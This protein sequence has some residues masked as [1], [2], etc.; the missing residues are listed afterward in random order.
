MTADKPEV[1]EAIGIDLR[2]VNCD[3]ESW[4]Q[5]RVLTAMRMAVRVSQERKVQADQPIQDYAMSGIAEGAAF[6]IS[7]TLGLKPAFDNIRPYDGIACMGRL[8]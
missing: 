5:A 3:Q 2:I 8:P 6:E 7:N 4:V 1:G